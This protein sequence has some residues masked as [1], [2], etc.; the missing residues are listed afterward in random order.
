[1][2]E[3]IFLAIVM[4]YYWWHASPLKLMLGYLVYF[5]FHVLFQLFNNMV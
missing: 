1:M 5:D 3:C 4:G 2:V